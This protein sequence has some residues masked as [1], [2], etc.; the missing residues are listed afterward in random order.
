MG[1]KAILFLDDE[2]EMLN[3]LKRSFRKSPCDTYFALNTAQ[4]LEILDTREISVLVTDQR[5]P[6][7]T[8]SEFL[9]IVKDS[10]PRV[11]RTILSGY[12]D[13]QTIVESI[14][15]G[16]VF[17]LITKPWNDQELHD[18]I[19]EC[20]AL[21][22]EMEECRHLRER[23]RADAPLSRLPQVECNPEH[24]L[25]VEMIDSIDQG[26]CVVDVDYRIVLAN[27]R[28]D[29]VCAGLFLKQ[30]HLHEIIDAVFPAPICTFIRNCSHGEDKD[31]R[32]NIVVGGSR[33]TLRLRSL[34]SAGVYRA[35]LFFEEL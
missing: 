18:T 6:D 8:G 9:R 23:S 22:E 25:L 34:H 17:R 4:A 16:G 15:R 5:M 31:S 26:C 27:H 7:M 19:D 28:L 20:L 10:H 35:L 3:A 33:I 24:A 30:E 32:L 12:T 13:V 1:R 21:Y 11:V 29:G 14:H 2:I